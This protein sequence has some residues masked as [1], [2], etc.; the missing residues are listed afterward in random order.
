[1]FQSFFRRIV[2]SIWDVLKVP[3]KKLF[4]FQI[5]FWD[6]S[7]SVGLS[8]ISSGGASTSVTGV[9]NSSALPAVHSSSV[10]SLSF[11]PV[12]ADLLLTSCS[13]G[14]IVYVDPSNR[15]IVKRVQTGH[16]VTNSCLLCDGNTSAVATEEGLVLMY[17]LRKLEK[18]VFFFTSHLGSPVT[19]LSQVN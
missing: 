2:I 18:P 5:V 8:K 11:S 16:V 19:H 3:S 9:G 1:M 15:S 6:V 17:D 12:I 7:A 10:T 4:S 14:S 13:D